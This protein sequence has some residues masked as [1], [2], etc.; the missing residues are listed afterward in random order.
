MLAGPGFWDSEIARAG[1]SR[2]ISP[3]RS[4]CPEIAGRGTVWGRNVYVR[5]HEQLIMEWSDPVSLSA[6]ILNGQSHQVE[7]AEVLAAVIRE[8]GHR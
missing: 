1:W 3:S 7:S 2:V 4:T 6:V 5:G 8:G